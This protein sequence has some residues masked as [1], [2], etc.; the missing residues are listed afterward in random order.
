MYRN[1]RW[2]LDKVWCKIE[3]STVNE[4]FLRESL[5]LQKT[6]DRVW[7]TKSLLPLRGEC[8][9]DTR[10]L[11]SCLMM[12]LARTDFSEPADP[13]IQRSRGE[14]RLFHDWNFSFSRTQWQVL[15]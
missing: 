3:R 11:R 12:Y 8:V 10:S 13:L 2:L 15:L 1:N 5:S 6:K 7:A 14:L 4:L 9:F